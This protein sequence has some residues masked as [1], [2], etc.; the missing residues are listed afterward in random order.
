MKTSESSPIHTYI[1]W[2]K[3][4]HLNIV[5]CFNMVKS[6]SGIK[7]KSRLIEFS[8][9]LFYGSQLTWLYIKHTFIIKTLYL[10][11]KYKWNKELLTQE[12]KKTFENNHLPKFTILQAYTVPWEAI[13]FFTLSNPWNRNVDIISS[14]SD[15]FDIHK[16]RGNCECSFI[17]IPEPVDFFGS[18][19]YLLLQFVTNIFLTK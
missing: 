16:I 13:N 12:K 4:C 19:K 11:K 2:I 1:E 3:F 15:P 17:F 14:L 10:A 18:D 7:Q 9:R 6:F 5:Q 8:S